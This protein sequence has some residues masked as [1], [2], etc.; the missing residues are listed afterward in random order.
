MIRNLSTA[1][2]IFFVATAVCAQGVRISAQD[3]LNVIT[4]NMRL[5]TPDDGIN[6]WPNRKNVFFSVLKN[7]NPHVFGIQEALYNQIQDAEKAFPRY[8]R[9]GEGRE[10]GIT[11]GEFS[12]IFFDT[13]LYKSISSGTFWLSQTPK[14]PGSMGWDATCTRVVSW[15]QL[16]T[17]AT[18]KLFFVFNTHFDHMGTMARRNSARLLLHAVDSLAAKSPAIILGDFNA[19]PS[20]EPYCILTRKSDPAHLTNAFYLAENA[21]TPFYTYTG[22]KVGGL[23]GENIDFIFLKPALKVL[24]YFVN[25][26]H[27]GDYYPSDHLPVKVIL[28]L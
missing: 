24:K 23:A 13:L 4:W 21:D 5:D 2:F 9:V 22:F 26:Y 3:T 28:V 7:E 15:V 11:K 17:I 18:G 25:T 19:D 6:A 20:S 16:R 12:P 1:V 14:V 8:K 27:S 10:N